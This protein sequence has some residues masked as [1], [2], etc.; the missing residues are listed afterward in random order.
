MEISLYHLTAVIVAALAVAGVL[1]VTMLRLRRAESGYRALTP[2]RIHK[3]VGQIESSHDKIAAHNAGKSFSSDRMETFTRRLIGDDAFEHM[4]AR[5]ASLLRIHRSDRSTSLWLSGCPGDNTGWQE[6]HALLPGMPVT[7]EDVSHDGIS[8][9]AVYSRDVRVGTLLMNEAEKALRLTEKAH[10]TG[11]YVAEQNSY[12][13]CDDMSLK[14]VLF[15]NKDEES[16]FAEPSLDVIPSQAGEK[17]VSDAEVCVGPVSPEQ[18]ER[19]AMAYA[20]TS[21]Y[22]FIHRSDRPLVIYTN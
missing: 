16:L 6:L 21:E 2:A 4:R 18:S 20:L 12:G 19:D 9:V 7:L 1:A 22:K 8:A 5:I 10:L 17:S 3:P 13:P 11:A 14:I 15:Y